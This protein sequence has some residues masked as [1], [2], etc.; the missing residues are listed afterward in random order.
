MWSTMAWRRCD[1]ARTR[2][3][4]R[5]AGVSELRL[6]NGSFAMRYKVFGRQRGLDKGAETYSA[7]MVS[8]GPSSLATTARR[9]SR[10]C[11]ACRPPYARSKRFCASAQR[12]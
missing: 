8:N 7:A 2:R 6:G 9:F 11:E 3:A 1:V 12:F 4:G 10:N 5:A